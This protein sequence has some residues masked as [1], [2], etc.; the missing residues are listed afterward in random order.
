M[1]AL[2]ARTPHTIDGMSTAFTTVIAPLGTARATRVKAWRNWCTVLTWAAT[3]SCLHQILPMPAS[4]LQALLWEFTSLGASNA[5]LKSVLDSII[6]RH[7]EARLPS[8]IQGHMS[9]TRLTGC[10]ARILGRPHNHKM[11]ITRDMV[12]SLLRS[13]PTD[14]LAFR[15]K[16]A[17]NTLTIG[18]MRPAEGAAALTCELVFDSDYLAGLHQYRHCATLHCLMRKNDQERKGHHMRF[19]VST[20]PDLDLPFQLSLFMDL[21]GTRPRTNCNGKRGKRCTDCPPLFPKLVKPAEG[22][23]AVASDPT[24]TPALHPVDPEF[25]AWARTNQRQ[26]RLK[27]A[28]SAQLIGH[29]DPFDSGDVAG[30]VQAWAK[31]HAQARRLQASAMAHLRHS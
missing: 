4:V 13:T 27:A 15:N 12:I 3:R 25:L 1:S 6:S 18:C 16:N 17:V 19:G 29:P 24:P 22:G 21:A 28:L 9:Y 20:D 23:W 14:L 31:R 30:Q 5:T 2:A 11:G 10:L 26:K 7:R 8:P